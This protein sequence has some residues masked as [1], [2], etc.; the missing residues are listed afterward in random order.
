MKFRNIWVSCSVV[1]FG[2]LVLVWRDAP[3]FAFKGLNPTLNQ[4]G[5]ISTGLLMTTYLKYKIHFT[6]SLQKLYLLLKTRRNVFKRGAIQ[7][8]KKTPQ[9]LSTVFS[10]CSEPQ[11]ICFFSLL[12]ISDRGGGIPHNIIDKVMDYHFSTAEESAQDPRMSNLF[13]T[14]TNSG[15]QSSPMHG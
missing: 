14:I 10:C 3:G 7:P 6:S 2:L 1:V 15:N 12:R 13:N 9:H 8:K 11:K 4:K 5:N